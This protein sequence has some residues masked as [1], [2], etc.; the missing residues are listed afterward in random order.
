MVN[1]NYKIRYGYV[2]LKQKRGGKVYTYH[3]DFCE[4]NCLW[5]EMYFYKDEEGKKMVQLYGILSDLTHLKNMIADKDCDFFSEWNKVVFYYDNMPKDVE[6]A[7][8]MLVKHGVNVQFKKCPT[9]YKR[10]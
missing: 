10:N 1:V 4:A 3:V 6:R 5:A 2:V 8:L 9:K 7:M